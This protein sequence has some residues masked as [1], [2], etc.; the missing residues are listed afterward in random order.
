[1]L[2][3]CPEAVVHL[4]EELL[5]MF[6]LAEVSLQASLQRCHLPLKLQQRALLLLLH[7]SSLLRRED[8]KTNAAGFSRALLQTAQ[9]CFDLLL[10]QPERV[11]F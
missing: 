3:R 9:T 10:L 7:H 2:W 8:M 5:Q 1:M 11:V 4:L 6:I